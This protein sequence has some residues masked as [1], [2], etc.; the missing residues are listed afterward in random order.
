MVD[1]YDALKRERG[2]HRDRRALL[3]V[4]IHPAG[5]ELSLDACSFSSLGGQ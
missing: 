2:P 3:A 5:V 4:A 1:H